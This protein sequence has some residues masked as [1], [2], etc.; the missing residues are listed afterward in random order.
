MDLDSLSESDF[1]L[2]VEAIYLREQLEK[3]RAVE[4][5]AR[6]RARVRWSWLREGADYNGVYRKHCSV[7]RRRFYTSYPYTGFCSDECRARHFNR[8]RARKRAVARRGRKCCQ[9]KRRFTP[10][11]A[12]AKFCSSKCR[13]ANH[14]AARVTVTDSSSETSGE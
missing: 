14:R 11:R 6:M 10:N 12:D 2:L 7:C 1:L 13:Q 5:H 4:S 8:R 3:R 9:C